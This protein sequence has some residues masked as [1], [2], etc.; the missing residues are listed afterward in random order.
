[1]IG[2]VKGGDSLDD[3][4]GILWMINARNPF[5]TRVAA[6]LK[7]LKATNKKQYYA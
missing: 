3:R 2:S 4:E 5:S 7:V 6:R 1:M